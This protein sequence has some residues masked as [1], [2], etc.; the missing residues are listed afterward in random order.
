[1]GLGIVG[2]A[3]GADCGHILEYPDGVQAASFS[4]WLSLGVLALLSGT[5]LALRLVADKLEKK[6]G[7]SVT[8]PGSNSTTRREIPIP[9]WGNWAQMRLAKI[10]YPGP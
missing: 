9:K 4:Q 5:V 1:M 3:F 2:E 7:R 10:G 6:L 8:G